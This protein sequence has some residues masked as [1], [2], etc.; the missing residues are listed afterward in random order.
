[1]KQLNHDKAKIP[2]R[3][4]AAMLTLVMALSLAA[5]VFPAHGGKNRRIL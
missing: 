1:M 5:P 3:I 4:L 2:R